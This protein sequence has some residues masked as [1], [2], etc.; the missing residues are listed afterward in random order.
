MGGGDKTLRPLGA[1]TILSHVVD[2]LR[3]QAHQIAI[4]ANSDP[5]R[6]AAFGLPV[7]ADRGDS[8]A[9]PLAGILAGMEW[10][11]SAGGTH[12]VSVAGDTPFFPHDLVERLSAA[13]E[14]KPDRIA[15]ASSGGRRHP[16]FAVWPLRLAGDLRRFLEEGKT[17]KVQAFIEDHEFIEVEFPMMSPPG[18]SIDP[19]FN[20]N[21]PD[22]LA[23]AEILLREVTA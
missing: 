4:S 3:P 9:G 6:F 22:D 2:R 18:G 5:A 15:V 7:L 17:L 11:T 1:G 16:V 21:T 12:I 10:A 13:I 19:F 23:R 8:Y 20:I 14:E